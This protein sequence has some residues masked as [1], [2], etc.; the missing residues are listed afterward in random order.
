MKP[1]DGRDS[2]AAGGV[3]RTGPGG[4]RKERGQPERRIQ[5]YTPLAGDAELAEIIE[6]D[7]L[8]R[9]PVRVV[10]FANC[11]SCDLLMFPAGWHRLCFVLTCRFGGV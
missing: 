3:M 6:R 11:V 10:T 9:N 7:V 2:R 5:Q 8:N 4:G 1:R